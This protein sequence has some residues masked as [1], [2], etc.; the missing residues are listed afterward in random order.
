MPWRRE[1]L[2]GATTKAPITARGG[3]NSPDPT[4][5]HQMPEDE[6]K[7]VAGGPLG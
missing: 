1:A 2:A 5:P 4:S 6:A 7:E 3:T